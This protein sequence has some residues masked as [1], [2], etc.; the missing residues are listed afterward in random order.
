MRDVCGRCARASLRARIEIHAHHHHMKNTV[1]IA[2]AATAAPFYV[3]NPHEYDN[4]FFV[5]VL[6]EKHTQWG[7]FLS[8]YI[9][10]CIYDAMI[11]RR[12]R[13]ECAFQFNVTATH[14]PL[15]NICTYVFVINVCGCCLLAHEMI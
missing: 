8:I 10:Q 14:T 11:P 4:F 13:A 5:S 7:V 6:C 9:F 2:R 3:I 15:L 12:P 1:M